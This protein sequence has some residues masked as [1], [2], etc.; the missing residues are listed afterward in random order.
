MTYRVDFEWITIPAGTFLMGDPEEKSL[1]M[2]AKYD[3]KIFLT[4]SPQKEV[5][6]ESFRI[7]AHPVTNAQFKSF[8]DSTGY[9]ANAWM[10]GYSEEKLDHPVRYVNLYDALT[11]CSWANCRLPTHIEWEKAARGPN[12]WEYPWGNTWD[13]NY[14]NNQE[15][16]K[17][18]STMPVNSFPQG[19]SFYGLSNMA[20]NVWEWT[21]T[22][23]V[24]N[25]TTAIWW[26]LDDPKWNLSQKQENLDGYDYTYPQLREWHV[27]KGG[28]ADSNR[29]GMRCSFCLTG[30]APKVQGDFF[31][32]R[33]VKL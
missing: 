9:L 4:Q 23:T 13:P 21:S 32:F 1:E 3:S 8:V 33:C 31:G 6:V 18:S 14:S 16:L 29:L 2:C 20:G 15:L 28:G 27:L 7:C 17:P 24:G 5:H 25:R 19:K 11:F 26:A 10:L 12:G 30:Y 22:T